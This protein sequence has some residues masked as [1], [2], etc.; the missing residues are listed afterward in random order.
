MLRTYARPFTRASRLSQGFGAVLSPAVS[1]SV[2]ETAGV[3]AVKTWVRCVY[4]PP[5]PE[6]RSPVIRLP[7]GKR[8]FVFLGKR[9][10]DGE[11]TPVL[12]FMDRS[13]HYRLLF[14]DAEEVAEFERIVPRLRSYLQLWERKA[15]VERRRQEDLAR[16]QQQDTTIQ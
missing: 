11:P 1:S 6:K 10:V 14:L 3:V 2:K 9:D 4:W 12:A 13:K 15:H 5:P 16:E 7:S 8:A